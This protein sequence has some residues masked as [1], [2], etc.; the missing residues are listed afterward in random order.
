MDSPFHRPPRVFLS[1][2]IL[3]P[4][5]ASLFVTGHSRYWARFPAAWSVMMTDKD[6]AARGTRG[7]HSQQLLRLPRQDRELHSVERVPKLR[8]V[9]LGFLQ[10]SLVLRR[11]LPCRRDLTQPCLPHREEEPAP[12]SRHRGDGRQRLLQLGHSLLEPAGT[13]QGSGWNFKTPN[14]HWRRASMWPRDLDVSSLL[15]P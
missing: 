4:V 14:V 9:A 7:P 5:S 10:P 8:R 11:R 6:A 13:I 15:Q 3:A 1:V 12:A 2:S